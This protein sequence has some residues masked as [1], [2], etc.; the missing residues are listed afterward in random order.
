MNGFM[1]D[2]VKAAIDELLLV[3]NSII[4]WCAE[5]VYQIVIV[6]VLVAFIFLDSIAGKAIKSFRERI[7]TQE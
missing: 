4:V 6:S 1:A 5:P 7:T 2:A 3:H